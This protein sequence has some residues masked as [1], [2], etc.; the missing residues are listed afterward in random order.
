MMT[1]LII[2]MIMMIM[3]IPII[4]PII[5]NM[6]IIPIIVTYNPQVGQWERLSP[7]AQA[8]YLSPLRSS[9]YYPKYDYM[10]IYIYIY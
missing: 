10:Y 3:I 8:C 6:R 4:V 9:D 7:M 5:V 2:T 1:T